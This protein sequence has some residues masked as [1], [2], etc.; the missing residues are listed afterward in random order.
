MKQEAHQLVWSGKTQTQR[1]EK[2]TQSRR[3]AAFFEFD[4]CQREVAS[5]VIF[6]VVVDMWAW[7]GFPCKIG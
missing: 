2:S 6:S 1:H 5:D 3:M 4:K 7:I